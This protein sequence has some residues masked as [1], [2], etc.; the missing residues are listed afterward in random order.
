M[1]YG[2]LPP[3]VQAL[4]ASLDRKRAEHQF[5]NDIELAQHLNISDKLLSFWR[6]GRLTRTQ[7]ALL[8]VLTGDQSILPRVTK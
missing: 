3:A 7:A 5:T 8:A 2:H 4:N 1:S 6:N